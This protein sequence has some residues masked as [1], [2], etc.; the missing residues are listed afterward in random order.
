MIELILPQKGSVLDTHT[1]TQNKFIRM[2]KEKG[3]DEALEWLLPVK[4]DKECSH[5]VEIKFEWT[6][7]DAQEFTFELSERDDFALAE[8]IKTKE[9]FLY[10]TNLKIGQKYFWRVNGCEPSFFE[11]LDNEYRFINVGGVLNV[12]DV[13]GIKIKQ[14]LL[15]RGADVDHEFKISD[16]GI[17]TF[18]DQLKIKTQMSLRKEHPE[19]PPF[20]VFSDK[21]NYKRL[22]YRP[23]TEIF[24][25][26]HREGIRKIME[27]LTDESNY[28]IYFHC[29]GGADRTGMIAMY[30][31]ALMGESEEEILIDYELTSLST[32][33]LG[34][35]EGVRAR[36]FRNRNNDYFVA[37]LDKLGYDKEEKN[38]VE[39]IRAFLYE[40]G[41]TE[42][43]IE[44]IKSIIA[45]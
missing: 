23:Y 7:D 2:I 12:R 8:T 11:T 45:K 1:E 32:Y 39:K 30:L 38:L 5:P 28:P 21:V 19:E 24:Y 29:A 6:C 25:D 14:G 36:G 31:R 33:A 43:V 27:Y 3:I 44:K 9:N 35:V 41:V 34:L 13:G 42:E 17:E 18:V 20:S 16:E 26:E 40:C 4:D 10:V 22:P 37:F 15:Y